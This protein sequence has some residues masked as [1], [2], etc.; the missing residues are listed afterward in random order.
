MHSLAHCLNLCLQE[1]AKKCK[2][3]RNALDAIQELTKLV[4]YSP[5]LSLVLQ[6]CKHQ[7]SSEATGLC[8]LYPTRWTVRTGAI[9]AVLRNYAAIVQALAQIA[10]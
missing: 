9:D 5:K 1:V 8:P 10:E 3:I 6:K 4:T 2:T 7:L